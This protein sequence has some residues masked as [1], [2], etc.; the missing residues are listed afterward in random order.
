RRLEELPLWDRP[1][2]DSVADTWVT[3][4]STIPNRVTD[5]WAIATPEAASAARAIKDFFIASYSKVKQRAP[6]RQ[7]PW[8]GAQPKH[9]P[10]VPRANLLVGKLILLQQSVRL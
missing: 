2:A 10:P 4:T 1:V 5:D 3:P 6:D 8:M 9:A 7:V